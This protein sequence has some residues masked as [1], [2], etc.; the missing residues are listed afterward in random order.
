M[1][2]TIVV[3]EDSM[4]FNLTA[5]SEHEKTMMEVMKN[6]QGPA[7]V[8]QGADVSGCR[9]GWVRDFGPKP[10]ITAIHIA[11]NRQDYTDAE[12]V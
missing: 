12:A 5:E 8:H 2:I 4:Q 3:T 7:T 10:H 9:G 6:Y 1:R 11:K